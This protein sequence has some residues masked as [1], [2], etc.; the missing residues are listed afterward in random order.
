MFAD[1][2]EVQAAM[3]PVGADVIIT[4]NPANTVSVKNV[5]MANL[6]ADDFMFF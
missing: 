1:F 5:L 2:A 4:D 6:G 3:T